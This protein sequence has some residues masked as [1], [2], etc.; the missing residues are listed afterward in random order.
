MIA[1]IGVARLSDPL[2][3]FAT[4]GRAMLRL[5]VFHVLGD[6]ELRDFVV[7]CRRFLR[8]EMRCL[9]IGRENVGERLPWCSGLA[10]SARRLAAQLPGC[11]KGIGEVPTK[12][13]FRCL[14]P[15]GIEKCLHL[16]PTED[17][18][19]VLIQPFELITDAEAELFHLL[20]DKLARLVPF[21]LDPLR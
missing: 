14:P 17:I 16:I 6:L 20:V 3:A 4:A 1:R 11:F 7:E 21:T 13:Q 5:L 9:S 18:A 12:C 8:G 19:Q 15:R 10:R 2:R